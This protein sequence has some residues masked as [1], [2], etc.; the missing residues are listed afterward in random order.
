MERGIEIKIYFSA[1]KVKVVNQ[2][3]GKAYDVDLATITGKP[4]GIKVEP[5]QITVY[6]NCKLER[7]EREN[8]TVMHVVCEID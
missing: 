4:F 5:S 1:G 7:K 6:G 8:K 2:D 3:T